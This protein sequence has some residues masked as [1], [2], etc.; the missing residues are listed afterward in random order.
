MV[1]VPGKYK[2]CETCRVRRVKVREAPFP[3]LGTLLACLAFD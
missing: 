2:G 1:G 3:L